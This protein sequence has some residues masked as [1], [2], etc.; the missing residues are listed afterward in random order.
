MKKLLLSV[1]LAFL[2]TSFISAQNYVWNFGNDATTFPVTASRDRVV[3]IN[4][5]TI[6]QNLEDAVSQ[7]TNTGAI[8]AGG[9]KNYEG[10]KYV[11]RFQFGGAGYT[12]GNDQQAVPTVFMPTQRYISFPVDGNCSISA[13]YFTGSNSSSRKIFVTD[14]DALVGSFDAVAMSGAEA[15]KST[16]EY[17]GPATT[18]YMYCNAASN[19]Y[20][21]EVTGTSVGIA[22]ES[23]DK[24]VISVEYYDVTGRKVAENTQGLILKKLSYDNGT[25]EVVKTIVK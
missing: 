11:N 9:S 21:L 17:T 7:I 25:T 6:T 5:L 12:G 23:A 10:T 2:A 24:T 4:N 16:V 18:L 19:L 15:L 13:I 1:S 20:Y 3:T 8:N 22:G 14:G